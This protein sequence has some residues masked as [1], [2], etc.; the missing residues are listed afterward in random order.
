MY[1]I[2]ASKER[3]EAVEILEIPGLF[4]TERIDRTTVPKGMYAYD[5]QASEEDWSQPCLIG[6]HIT[7]EHF[8]TVLTA[9]PVPLS[10]NGYRD[11]ATGDFAT[12]GGAERL[13]VAEFEAKWLSPEVRRPR[14]PLRR[15]T[16]HS[17]PAPVR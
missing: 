17:R 8:G 13:T 15:R 11:L 5:M 1:S 4:T 16:G 14:R 6:R 10:Q 9:S 12:N 7:V 2:D 3:F